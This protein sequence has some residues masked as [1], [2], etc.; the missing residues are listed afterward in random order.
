MPHTVDMN[1]DVM[2][3]VRSLSSVV[4][5]LNRMTTAAAEELRQFPEHEERFQGLRMLLNYA[6]QMYTTLLQVITK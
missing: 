1:H 3:L 2:R 5:I 6:D 4:Q